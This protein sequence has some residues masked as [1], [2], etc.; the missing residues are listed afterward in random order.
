VVQNGVL[1]NDERD[2]R[3][4]GLVS[5]SPRWH[6]G[7]PPAR[8]GTY[9]KNYAGGPPR[10]TPAKKRLLDIGG[11]IGVVSAELAG[12]GIADVTYV[13]ASPAYLEVARGELESRYASRSIPFVLSDFTLMADTL[14]D[15]DVVTLDRVVGCY[16]DADALLRGAA[17]QTRQLPGVHVSPRSLVHAHT[18]WLRDLV[19]RLRGNRFRAFVHPAKRMSATL[20]AAGLVRTARPAKLVWVLDLYQRR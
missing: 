11:G 1:G 10:P 14:P 3:T 18:H 9:G 17:A 13:E 4:S 15:G 12:A 19:R 20:E 5:R 8:A 7:L 6:N 2:L 16:P